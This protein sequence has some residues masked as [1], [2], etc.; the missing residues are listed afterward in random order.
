MKRKGI[1]KAL[2]M[3]L[4]II[5]LGFSTFLVDSKRVKAGLKPIFVIQEPDLIKDGG[6]KIYWGIGY[7]VIDY[8]IIG[9]KKGAVIGS[10]FLEYDSGW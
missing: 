7:K 6:T 9:G 2:I 10:W 5:C 8:H 4:V 3:I 1:K